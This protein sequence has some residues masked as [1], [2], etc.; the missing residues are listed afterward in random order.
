M[1]EQSTNN[2]NGIPMDILGE[3]IETIKNQPTF[4]QSRF[5]ISNKW[6]FGAQNQTSITSFYTAKEEF[7]HKQTFTLNA[8]EPEI[9]AGNDSAPN[10]VEH[11][12][13]ALTS[14]VTSSI[15]YHAAVNNVNIYEIESEIEGEIDLRG[16][17]GISEEVRKGFQNITMNF[18][19]KSDAESNDQLKSFALFSPVF[20]VVTNGTNVKININ[21]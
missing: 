19:I 9:L 14:C 3:T 6:L 20:D 16:F 13:N 15:V 2:M 12:L 8:D 21:S 18:K 1:T 10:P 5:H 4:A 7:F 11:L 17:T